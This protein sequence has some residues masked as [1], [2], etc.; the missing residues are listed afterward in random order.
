MAGAQAVDH[1]VGWHRLPVALGIPMLVGLRDRL[2]ATNLHDRGESRTDPPPLTGEVL[3]W[4]TYDGTFNDLEHPWMGSVHSRFGRNVPLGFTHPEPDAGLLAPNPKVVS[5]ELLTR[6][7]FLP[8]HLNA[9]TAAWIQF[10][11]HDWFDHGQ[12]E[13]YPW[14]DHEPGRPLASRTRQ[15][16]ARPRIGTSPVYRSEDTHWW[17]ASQLYGRT[18]EEARTRRTG[19]DGRLK[20]VD[21]LLAALRAARPEGSAA[22]LWLGSLVLGLLFALEHNAICD[23]LRRQDGRR[24]T[25]EELFQIARLVN[26]ALIAK[27][28]TLDWTPAVLD[29]PTTRRAMRINWSGAL[30]PVT[31][32]VGRLGSNDFLFGIPGSPTDHHGAPYCLTEEFASVYRM[33]SLLPDEVVLESPGSG[34]REEFGLADLLGPVRAGEQL[35][36]WRLP[37]LFYSLGRA[38]AGALSLHNFPE[39]LRD[40]EPPSHPAGGHI[41]LAAIDILRDRERAVPRYN[42]FRQLVHCRPV[43]TFEEL[44]ADPADVEVLR[45]LYEG[46]IDRVDLMVGLHAEPKPPGFAISDTAFRIFILMA[47]RRL[48]SDRFF[49]R[50][51]TPERYTPAGLRWIRENDF[52][53]VLLRHFPGLAPALEGVANPFA[54]WRAPR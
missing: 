22:N 41:D 31:E 53:S 19:E 7:R 42:L 8:T 40:F 49:T 29:H 20:P 27:I 43:R 26:G 51:F 25:D 50:D 45:E 4:R 54:A 24:R 34:R 16:T 46:D 38:R 15:D 30:G 9:L 14:E 37:D 36:K 6:R 35:A 18:E 12:P 47:S 5:R 3:R 52:R 33:H 17:D 1:R 48:K 28:H 32:R 10:E 21:G 11:T 13:P 44:A 23:E 39:T 2:R